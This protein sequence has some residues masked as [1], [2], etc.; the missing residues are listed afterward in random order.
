MRLLTE[1][2]RAA[3][4]KRGSTLLHP[5]VRPDFRVIVYFSVWWDGP[6][7]IQ[8]SVHLIHDIVCGPQG[9]LSSLPIKDTEA[10]LK[11]LTT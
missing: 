2:N 10:S 6:Y 1:S 5:S 11:L 9:T 8:Q 7:F 4:R 3:G